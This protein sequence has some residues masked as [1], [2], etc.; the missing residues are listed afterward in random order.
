[1]HDFEKWGRRLE[2]ESQSA[3]QF[4]KESSFLMSHYIFFFSFLFSRAED[5]TQGLALASQA[6][7]H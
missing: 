7:Y 6:L 2:E 3:G 4:C 5:Q 1:M